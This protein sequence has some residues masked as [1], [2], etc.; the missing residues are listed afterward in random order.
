MDARLVEGG[1]SFTICTLLV[2]EDVK[3][4]LLLKTTWNLGLDSSSYEARDACLT[5]LVFY[6]VKF[7]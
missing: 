5:L 6:S 4:V 2:F 3:G 7:R 1:R